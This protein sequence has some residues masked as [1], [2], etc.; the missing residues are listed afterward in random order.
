[1]TI[2]LRV[3]I[4]DDS[5]DDAFLLV[6]YLTRGG[7][8]LTWKRVDTEPA[9]I[10]ILQ[11]QT[12]DIILSDFSM[13]RFNGLEALQ[14]IRQRNFP[15][16]FILVS[17]AIGE[18]IAVEAIKAG[19]QDYVLKDN[20]TRLVPSVERSLRE[21]QERQVR[22]SRNRISVRLRSATTTEEILP[23]FLEEAQLALNSPDG[24]VLM[25]YP[26][27]SQLVVAI[28][29]GR[30]E[31]FQGMKIPLAVEVKN[32][33]TE[34][35]PTFV[36]QNIQ[37][38]SLKIDV[39]LP[40]SLGPVMAI[41]IRS[42]NTVLGILTVGRDLGKPAA[43][44]RENDLILAATIA[45][46]GGN[47]LHR[48]RMFEQTQQRV[49]RLSVLHAID[50]TVSSS[51]SISITLNLIL[52]QIVSQLNITAADVLAYNS[53]AHLLEFAAGR[54]F[55]N[56]K[57]K[58]TRFRLGQSFP[59]NAVLERKA[60]SIMDLSSEP[61]FVQLHTL[62]QERVSSYFAV[63]LVAKGQIKGVL[64]LFHKEPILSDPEL[65][66][67]F[68]SLAAQTAIAMDNSELFEGLKRSNLE[69]TRAYDAVIESWAHSLALRESFNQGHAQR[70]AE[71]TLR[72][73]KIMAVNEAE[74][75]HIRRG[76]LLHDIGMIGIPEEILHK[77]VAL[78][79][80]ERI[81][82]NNHPQIAHDLLA[83]I[84]FLAPALDIPTYHH[85]RWDGSG[86]PEGLKG[87]QIPLTARL[88]AVVDV[89][90][91]LTN[92]R[93]YRPAWS[94]IEA[95]Q[96]I[97]EQAGKQFDPNVVEKFLRELPLLE[98]RLPE[99]QAQ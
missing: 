60:V 66:D 44:Y 52:D 18:E 48:A 73:A 13:P 43:D 10:Q 32:F 70:T 25:Y 61:A 64:E 79:E 19:A 62:E 99:K 35:S 71:M 65:R 39:S 12:W 4:V 42:A 93:N 26:N 16:P 45:E 28:G 94:Q 82:V 53:Q 3:L 76:S 59:G 87:E 41:P 9:L 89:W 1:M 34:E 51:L 55:R 38:E 2:P 17:G 69:L 11:E 40:A 91:A 95:I 63:P 90:D 33:L 6:R 37:A 58:R 86:Y 46:L 92:E 22:E 85:E 77:K 50:M 27:T 56:D 47:A 23:G 30:M 98:N 88:F 21:A 7:F 36:T 72:F 14:V 20:L 54:G 75:P 29:N 96:Y 84:H 97:R 83:N 15:N 31:A 8:E 80:I 24:A 49:Q 81:V 5:E 74:L 78:T 68:E 67:F 57:V